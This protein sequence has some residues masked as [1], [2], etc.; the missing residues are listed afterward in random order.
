MIPVILI[1]GNITRASMSEA[2]DEL[3]QCVAELAA[4]PLG[5]ARELSLI[6][7]SNGGNAPETFAFKD[8]LIEAATL[9]GITIR[10]KIYRAHSGASIIALAATHRTIVRHGT[11]GFHL[12]CQNLPLS[13]IFP[14]K[15]E[16]MYEKRN[17]SLDDEFVVG[18]LELK[19]LSLSWISE[20]VPNLA[21][22]KLR[23]LESTCYL[24]LTPVECLEYGIV[25]EI[26]EQ[27]AA[28]LHG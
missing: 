22:A 19:S 7:N 10:A 24:N 25:H 4:R 20:R 3:C 6:I 14:V 21:P 23:E 12:G 27:K 5:I 18:L 2:F 9:H 11:F 16:M 8:L 28:A 1:Q 26:S 13:Q 17:P 15:V